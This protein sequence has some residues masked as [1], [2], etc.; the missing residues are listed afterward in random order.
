[1]GIKNLYNIIKTHAPEQLVRYHLTE[2]C[3][4]KVAVDVSVFLYKFIR[5]AGFGGWKDLFIRMLCTLVESGIIPICIYDGPNAPAEKMVERQRRREDSEKM[6]QKAVVCKNLANYVRECAM[7]EEKIP[8]EIID[9]CKVIFKESIELDYLKA[10]DVLQAL[11]EKQES[12]ERQSLPIT[13]EHTDQAFYISNDVLGIRSFITSGEAEG[14]CASLCIS[15]LA[16]AVLTEDTDVLAYGTPFMLSFYIDNKIEDK[17]V[18]GIFLPS[19]L[20]SLELT[21]KQFT[22][23]CILLKCDYNERICC[24]LPWGKS[25]KQVSIGPVKAFRFIKEYS[26]LER[27]IEFSDDPAPLMYERCRELFTPRKISKD[28]KMF[29]LKKPNAK[30]LQKLKDD[31]EIT[32]DPGYVLKC[33][34]VN[35]KFND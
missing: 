15:G 24:R 21:Q 18:Q 34:Q 10:F 27:I 28:E 11:V 5:T 35:M 13:K 7:T 26:T 19:L 33:L 25:K 22:D 32:I 16:D 29:T 6:R 14:E 2:L 20:A 1:M 12:L 31:M 3:G 30:L 23:L 4:Y 17:R 9:Q 8:Q